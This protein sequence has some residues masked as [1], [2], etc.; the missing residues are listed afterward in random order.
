VSEDAFNKHLAGVVPVSIA[1]KTKEYAF[2]K[3]V[4]GMNLRNVTDMI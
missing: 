1:A 2:L 4:Q 3:E